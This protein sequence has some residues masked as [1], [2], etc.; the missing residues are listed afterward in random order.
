M[1]PTDEKPPVANETSG[2]RFELTLNTEEAAE[3][4]KKGA[5]FAI[6]KIVIELRKLAKRCKG[7]SAPHL[8]FYVDALADNI[9]DSPV[10]ITAIKDWKVVEMP[11]EGQRTVNFNLG[12][13]Q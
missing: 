7:K 3:L 13:E 4:V 12:E 1:S 8:D 5:E 2:S 11:I 9:Q 10:T 6:K